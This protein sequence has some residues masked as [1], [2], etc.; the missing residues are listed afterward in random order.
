MRLVRPGN[1][2]LVV[3]IRPGVLEYILGLA[4]IVPFL[5]F[6]QEGGL[7][8]DQIW[9]VILPP[10]ITGIFLAYIAEITDFS[11][12]DEDGEPAVEP[13]RDSDVSFQLGGAYLVAARAVLANGDVCS[14]FVRIGR[15]LNL[16]EA[17]QVGNNQPQEK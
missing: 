13:C 1:G 7:G 6:F 8:R 4:I 11:P 9:G 10:F 5:A 17:S 14:G 2:T 12:D 16:V 15:L 3:Q